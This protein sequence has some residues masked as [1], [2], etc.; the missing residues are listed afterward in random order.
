[1]RRCEKAREEVRGRQRRE[2][3]REGVRRGEKARDG[4]RAGEEKPVA[5]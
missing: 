4:A 1:M 3:M 5:F 2:R